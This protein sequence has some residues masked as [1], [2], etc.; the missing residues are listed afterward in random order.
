MLT[1]PVVMLI[2]TPSLS[3]EPPALAVMLSAAKHLSRFSLLAFALL[4]LPSCF[5]LPSPR[6]RGFLASAM[7]RRFFVLAARDLS[8]CLPISCN[9]LG[10]GLAIHE[11][12]F[13]PAGN[14]ASVAQNFKM[15][16]DG[17][18]GNA[19]HRHNLAAV[20]ALRRGYG[21][22]NPETRLVG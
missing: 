18:R 6:S 16:R 15:M 8:E 3:A 9:R 1:R 22:K 13:V 19:M 21:L 11:L 5:V 10:D 14:Q 2:R 20:Y 7:A 4:L 12:A 17:C